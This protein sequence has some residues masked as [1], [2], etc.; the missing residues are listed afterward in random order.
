MLPKTK[1]DG[2][3]VLPPPFPPKKK[4]TCWFWRVA[5]Q[6]TL[7]NPLTFT[8]SLFLSVS[9]RIVSLMLVPVI[10]LQHSISVVI[11]IIIFARTTCGRKFPR[12]TSDLFTRYS[13]HHKR[14]LNRY[15]GRQSHWYSP[16]A[17]H[18]LQDRLCLSSMPK[19][20]LSS[21]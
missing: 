4:K 6:H 8:L 5:P 1:Q 7:A 17:W 10:C 2:G 16:S 20:S 18:C 14:K 9:F 21:G 13:T 15:K 3:N 12:I 19:C 11:F